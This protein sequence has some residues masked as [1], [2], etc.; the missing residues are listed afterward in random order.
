[1]TFVLDTSALLAQHRDVEGSDRVHS[2]FG[3][4]KFIRNE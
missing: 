4:A 2:L 3:D 1:M